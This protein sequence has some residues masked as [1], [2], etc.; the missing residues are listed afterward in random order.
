MARTSGEDLKSHVLKS[1]IAH[2]LTNIC[3]MVFHDK[4]DYET[5]YNFRFDNSICN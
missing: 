4:N 2:T 1:K 5:G 3:E